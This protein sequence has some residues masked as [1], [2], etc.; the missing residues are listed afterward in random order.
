VLLPLLARA[1]GQCF[2]GNED[3]VRYVAGRMNAAEAPRRVEAGAAKRSL[4]ELIRAVTEDD[5]EHSTIWWAPLQDGGLL[6]V[7]SEGGGCGVL[8]VP[9]AQWGHVLR[10]ILG[11]PV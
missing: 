5:R 10:V 8:Q 2:A 4:N 1:N 3:H 9:P 11:T 7:G 6:I